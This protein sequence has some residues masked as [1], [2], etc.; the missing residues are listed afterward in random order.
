MKLNKFFLGLLGL[1]AMVMTSCSDSDDYQWASITGGDQ[2][3]FSNTL[4]TTRN[5]S[6]SDTKFTIPVTRVTTTNATTVNISLTSDDNFL[7]APSSVSFPAGASTA[8]IEITY[9]PEALGYDNFKNAVLKIADESQTNAYGNFTYSFSAGIPSP[10]ESL[11]KG[12]I[13]DNFWFEAT[14]SVTIM[15]NTQKPNEFR[16]MA[17]FEG[18]AS[19]AGASLD[20]NQEPYI[21]LTLLK[22]GDTFYGVTVTKNDLVGYTDICTGYFHSSYEADV[23]MLFPGRFT[24][25][26]SEDFWGYNKVVE[27]QENGLPGRIQ[28]APYFYMFGV[29]GWNNTQSDDVVVIDFPGYAPKDLSA[30]MEYL[31]VLTDPAGAA[32]AAVNL[33][34]GADVTDARALVVSADADADAV[35]D[36][37]AAG[38]VEAMAV[39]AGTNYV[40]ITEGLTGK[41]MVVLAIFDEGNLKNVST[42]AFEYYG[43]GANPWEVFAQGDYVYTQ[44]FGSEDEPET[45]AGLEVQYNAEEDAYRITHWGYNVDFTF[46]W[47]KETNECHVPSQFTGYTHSSYG[48]VYVAEANDL[49]PKWGVPSSSY[50]P[51]TRTFSFG[52]A[53]YVSAGV[54][55]AG[56]ETFTLT[57]AQARR[58]GLD[59]KSLKVSSSLNSNLR[60]SHARNKA[61]I[62]RDELVD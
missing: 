48:E 14:A 29:G 26:A 55:G 2:V 3:Y 8:D 1:S 31:G 38:D 42:T 52:V 28:L 62:S 10:Y 51:E 54:F 27:W 30:E 7:S 6:M 61:V 9:D 22:P 33:S 40:P 4:P 15:Q 50:D 53:Y 11:G 18:L 12:K 21:Q 13:T 34:F 20:G 60:K 39:T 25:M 58:L 35:A 37:I 57:P 49:N 16:I 45:D 17:P 47:N 19:A 5:L 32:S 23:Y 24:S 43:G 36:A 59:K 41:L 46:T 56:V 44:F